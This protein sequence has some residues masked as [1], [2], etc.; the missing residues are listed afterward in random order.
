MKKI[1]VDDDTIDRMDPMVV[2]EPLW[3]SVNIYGS[4]QEYEKGLIPF[5]EQQRSVFAIMWLISEVFNGGFYQF[6]TNSTGI[7]WEDA[8]NGFKIVGIP[9]A[10][11]IVLQSVKLFEPTPSFNREEREDYLD[12]CYVEFEF[13]DELIHDLDETINLT[14]RIADFIDKNRAAFYFQGEVQE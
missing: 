4:K 8:L 10:H 12:S 3:L 2:I 6:Y 1:V 5:S 7:V 13:Q 14:N 9:E 11:E